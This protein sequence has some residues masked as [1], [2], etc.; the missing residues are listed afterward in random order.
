MHI[1]S[2]LIMN[3]MEVN[4]MKKENAK[5]EEIKLTLGVYLIMIGTL[6]MMLGLCNKVVSNHSEIVRFDRP[7]IG[8][9]NRY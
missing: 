3:Y 1:F 9:H 8:I 2:I 7:I 5:I 4:Y 6:I